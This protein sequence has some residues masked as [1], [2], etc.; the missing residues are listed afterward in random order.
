MEFPYE[1]VELS[2]VKGNPSRGSMYPNERFSRL[3]E[4]SSHACCALVTP[5]NLPLTR[6]YYI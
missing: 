2:V 6:S 3:P 1:M 4:D 5:K